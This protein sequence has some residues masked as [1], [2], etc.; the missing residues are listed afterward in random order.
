MNYTIDDFIIGKD[1]DPRIAFTIASKDG[2]ISANFFWLKN[3]VQLRG[4]VFNDDSKL[5]H[6]AYPFANKDGGESMPYDIQQTIVQSLVKRLIEM[7]VPK[8]NS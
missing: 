4:L 6:I 8:L 1:S 3:D 7:K 5:I 2:N